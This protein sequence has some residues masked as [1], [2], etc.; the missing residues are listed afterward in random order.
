MDSS[1]EDAGSSEGDFAE[2]S[3]FEGD[4][5]DEGD[6]D[7][8]GVLLTITTICFAQCRKLWF[9]L[10]QNGWGT[11]KKVYY[12]ADTQ[13]YELESDEERAEM[14][15]AESKRLQQQNFAQQDEEVVSISNS[16]RLG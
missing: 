9:F 15:E 12:G 3:H 13:D 7:E 8:F 6:D 1:E 2:A 11:K 4:D 16:C 10:G 5:E 14:E